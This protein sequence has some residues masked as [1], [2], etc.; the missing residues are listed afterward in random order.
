MIT[1]H[2]LEGTI[3]GFRL[4]LMEQGPPGTAPRV[5]TVVYGAEA[6]TSPPKEDAK[7][8]LAECIAHA[9]NLEELS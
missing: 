8:V 1:R 4:A 3:A 5:Y 2:L 6:N 9:L 7:K